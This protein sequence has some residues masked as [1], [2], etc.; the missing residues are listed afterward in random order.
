MTVNTPFQAA[1]CSSLAFKPDL[2]VSTS[3]KTSRADGASLTAKLTV[4]GALGTQANISKVKVELPKAL[5]SRLTDASESV[6]RRAVRNQPGRVSARVD[7]RARQGDHPDPPR[8]AGRPRV[9]RLP[10]RRSIPRAWSRA[11]GLRVHDRSHRLDVHQQTGVTSST[12]KTVPD[13]P[14]TSFELTLPEGPYSALTALGNLCAARKLTMPTEVVAQN[15]AEIEQ[16]TKIA[17]TG[18]PKAKRTAHKKKH[19]VK[20]KKNARRGGRTR[21]RSVRRGRR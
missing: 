5:P 2:T 17:V 7:H 20:A 9:L 14:V 16:S 19:G 6:H 8:P 15:G 10:R 4:L 1:D 12:F 13:Q 11:P 21:G 18:C 3:A